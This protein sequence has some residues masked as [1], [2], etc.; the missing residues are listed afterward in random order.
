MSIVNVSDFIGEYEI[1]QIEQ[2]NVASVVQKYI[3]K[4]EADYLNKVLGYALNQLYN[5]G[6]IAGTQAYL[7]IKNGSTYTDFYG[8]VVKYEGMENAIRNYIYYHYISTNVS[9]TTGSGEKTMDKGNA[10]SSM[11]KQIRVWNEMVTIN[12]VLRAFLYANTT[13]YGSVSWR[14]NEMFQYQNSLGL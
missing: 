10:V 6:I 14:Y 7:A 13:V 4:Y 8:D 2:A 9:F 1:A 12:R 3:D 11:D 5:T